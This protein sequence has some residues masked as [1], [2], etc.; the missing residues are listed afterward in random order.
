MY[1]YRERRTTL[2]ITIGDHRSVEFAENIFEH[3][4]RTIES[5]NSNKC[6]FL[7]VIGYKIERKTHILIDFFKSIQIYLYLKLRLVRVRC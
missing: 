2:N 7:L 1:L 3:R 4:F 6:R 5:S